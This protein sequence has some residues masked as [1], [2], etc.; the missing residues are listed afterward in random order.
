MEV[1]ARQKSGKRKK[2]K[3]SKEKHTEDKPKAK[4]KNLTAFRLF[5]FS[6]PLS[7]FDIIQSIHNKVWACRSC[8]SQKGKDGLYSFYKKRLPD[9]KKFFD[10]IP[11]LVEK[12]YLKSV[13]QCL[14]RCTGLLHSGDLDG[15]GEMTVLDIDFALKHCGNL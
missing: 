15:D 9:E 12:K 7:S 1:S 11:A 3:S 10:R 14:S 8:N 13:Y 2:A 4:R 5:N 6:L